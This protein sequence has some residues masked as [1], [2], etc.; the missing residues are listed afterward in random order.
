MERDG[1]CGFGIFAICTLWMRCYLHWT[2]LSEEFELNCFQQCTSMHHI[3]RWLLVTV[4]TDGKFKPKTAFISICATIEHSSVC[5]D[6]FLLINWMKKKTNQKCTKYMHDS[7]NLAA[8]ISIIASFCCC[9]F[10]SNTKP[11]IGFGLSLITANNPVFIEKL[12]SRS[13]VNVNAWYLVLILF[14]SLRSSNSLTFSQTLF[15]HAFFFYRFS[16]WSP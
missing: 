9:C 5:T 16:I 6:F 12:F 1:I 10:F 8:S 15:S 11:S 3:E 13:S 7:L 4:A 14:T 2:E